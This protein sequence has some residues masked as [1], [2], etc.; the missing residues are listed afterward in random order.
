MRSQRTFGVRSSPLQVPSGDYEIAIPDEKQFGEM[1]CLERKRA[2]RSRKPFLLM[3]LDLQRALKNDRLG[4]LVDNVWMSICSASRDSDIRGWYLQEAV[5]GIIFV[6]I[7][8]DGVVPVTDVIQAKVHSALSTYLKPEELELITIST[9]LQPDNAANWQQ[10]SGLYRDLRQRQAGRKLS[11]AMKR[12]LDIIGSTTA[13]FALLPLMGALALLIKLSSK[14]PV[15]FRQTRVGYGGRPFTF[16]KFRTMHDG[17]DS[18][19]HKEY[20]KE[21]IAGQASSSGPAVVYKI[22]DDPRVTKIGKF[23]RKSSFDEL[24]QFWNVLKG[25]MSLVGPRPP[26]PY[27]VE[28]YDIWHRRRILEA[29]PGLTGLWQTRG[30]S[31]TTFDEMVRLDLQYARSWSVWLDLKILFETPRA[32]ISGDGAY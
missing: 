31:R 28:C 32:M 11:R 25:D 10:W 12:G 8:P 26:I 29:K 22:E 15:L 14:G 30:R 2:E 23:L 24:P 27:E 9:Y 4:R 19:V 1:L 13:L 18:N 5:L 21:F 17:N 7:R 3:L 20:I 6:E 16:F